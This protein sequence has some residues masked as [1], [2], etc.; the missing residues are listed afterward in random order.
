[1]KMRDYFL[2]GYSHNALRT[3]KAPQSPPH[4]VQERPSEK[5]SGAGILIS[6]ALEVPPL[7]DNI[8]G[9]LQEQGIKLVT[10]HISHNALPKLLSGSFKIGTTRKYKAD[11]TKNAGRLGDIRE[12]V[13]R[14]VLSHPLG[15]YDVNVGGNRFIGC[16][17]N[18]FEHPIAMELSA[19]D[20]CSC[21][22]RGDFSKK[23]A[24]TI[25]MNGNYDLDSYVVY[26]F[27]KLISALKEGR[28]KEDR[29]KSFDIIGRGVLYGAKDLHFIADRYFAA[30]EKSAH[31]QIWL[32]TVFVKPIDYSH[33][34]E[35]RII[36]F[37]RNAAGRIP[38][39]ADPVFIEDQRIADAIVAYGKF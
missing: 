6:N 35:V 10:K 29:I 19:N 18:G 38:D 9:R 20:Y 23:R 4:R 33:E 17:I 30:P 14:Y 8:I 15:Q 22:S 25:R 34:E 16:T 1:M 7:D 31:F 2:S 39:D 27:E 13:Q 26:D 28:T 11:E 3:H 12:G 37:D 24:N 21:L 32:D 5:V 36:L